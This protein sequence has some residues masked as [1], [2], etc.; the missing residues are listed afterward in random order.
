MHRRHWIWPGLP[1]LKRLFHRQR[2]RGCSC[3]Q[4]ASLHPPTRNCRD[5]EDR[6]L[7]L[8]LKLTVLYRLSLAGGLLGEGD[9]HDDGAVRRNWDDCRGLFARWF[10]GPISRRLVGVQVER[11]ALARPDQP[12][13]HS[14]G[15]FETEKGP[16]LDHDRP[17]MINS[18]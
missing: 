9:G 6:C 15:I 2:P 17:N 5:D 13:P 16:K 7:K 18:K 12:H 10:L 1:P 8:G 3:R 11:R 4:G 14:Q